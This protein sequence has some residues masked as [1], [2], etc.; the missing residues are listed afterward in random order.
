MQALRWIYPTSRPRGI[1]M[2]KDGIHQIMQVKD[3][4]KALKFVDKNAIVLLASDS[5]G[6]NF[7]PLQAGVF[8]PAEFN[9]ST[10]TYRGQEVKM[11]YCENL[12]DHYK[13][14]PIYPLY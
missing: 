1:N 3:L 4:I 9:K 7:S 10:S 6:N 13:V 2:I 14:L 11:T 8:A 5:E 12:P